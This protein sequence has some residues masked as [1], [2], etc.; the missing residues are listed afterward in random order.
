MQGKSQTCL[1]MSPCRLLLVTG[2]LALNFEGA[3]HR[4][5]QT[6]VHIWPG[7]MN[8]RVPQDHARSIWH[9]EE[10]HLKNISLLK[11]CHPEVANK[12]Q[13]FHGL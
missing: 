2:S 10:E 8:D 4:E 6:P 13:M 3:D 11:G 12:I 9:Q 1:E 5:L 7:R